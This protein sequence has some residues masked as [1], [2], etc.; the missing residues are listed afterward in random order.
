MAPEWVKMG[1]KYANA[2]GIQIAKM[3]CT[4]H[5]ET[6]QEYGVSG[7]PTLKIFRAG[8]EV[9][10]HRSG[11]DVATLS[12]VLEEK[13]GEG[14]TEGA[15][16]ELPAEKEEPE[17]EEAPE[18]AKELESGLI[19]LTDAN[20]A[21]YIQT[22]KTT[23]IKFYAPWCGHCKRLAPDWEKLAFSFKE[24][25]SVVIAKVDCTE[26]REICQKYGVRGY[27][28]LKIF[29]ANKELGE[30]NGARSLEAMTKFVTDNFVDEEEILKEKR[31]EL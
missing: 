12:Q 11:R 14:Q 10:S 22:T 1:V 7:F 17:V 26:N 8:E 3:D 31:D 27:P 9:H 2:K 23:F 21:S 30:H 18:P 6:C 5:R 16:D 4:K 29:R 20:A 13:A 24:N 25:P 15:L 28:T 19:V